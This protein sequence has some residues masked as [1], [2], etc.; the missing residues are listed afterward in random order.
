[1]FVLYVS[2]SIS[3]WQISSSKPFS[4]FH[5]YALIYDTC[6]SVLD[7]L[8][9]VWQSLDS[10]TSL[11]IWH[12]FIRL[13]G[14]VIF[15]GRIA[16]WKLTVSGSDGTVHLIILSERGSWGKHTYDSSEMHYIDWQWVNK[17]GSKGRMG[18]YPS[19]AR[20]Q[21]I[22]NQR[23]WVS[24]LGCS[25]GCRLLQGA[26]G[27]S[28]DLKFPPAGP[29]SAWHLGAVA[30]PE[31]TS[32]PSD[33]WKS[34][35]LMPPCCWKQWQTFKLQCH[36]Y[37]HSLLL[38]ALIKMYELVPC[39]P[40]ASLICSRDHFKE[41]SQPWRTSPPYPKG[42]HGPVTEQ[43]QAL[44]PW[45]SIGPSWNF[46]KDK[47]FRIKLKSGGEE[48]LKNISSDLLA[49]DHLWRKACFKNIVTCFHC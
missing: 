27:H 12:Y 26:Y 21:V 30:A 24:A 14:W 20:Y 22:A 8:Y 44:T 34:Q 1:M 9:P 33:A 39:P 5:I 47:Y 17:A 16:F 38:L 19:V 6:F 3:A 35:Y 15:Q 48:V 11:Q 41:A 36:L 13:Y 29:F 40:G 31:N 25:E 4:R 2:V 32:P 43:P 37:K 7:L 46:P 18:R 49:R 23:Q 28:C 42:K 45:Q 10:S